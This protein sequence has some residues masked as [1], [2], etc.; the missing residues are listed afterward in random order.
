ME[1][2]SDRLKAEFRAYAQMAAFAYG[3]EH[4]YVVPGFEPHEWVYAA[5]LEAM[6]SGRDDGWREG[7]DEG[8]DAGV[9][10]GENNAD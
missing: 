7:Y 8:Y 9:Q 2:I 10:D 1:Q 6:K 4:S 5:M 3:S